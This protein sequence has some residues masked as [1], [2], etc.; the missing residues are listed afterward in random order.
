VTRAARQL[1]SAGWRVRALTRRPDSPA[2]QALAAA[3]GE[4]VDGDMDFPK[5]L[6]AA[7]EGVYGVFSVQQGVLGSPS[8][9][10]DSEV[11]QGRNVADA[12]VVARAAHLVYTSVS[13]RRYPFGIAAFEG[14]RLVEEYIERIGIPA[15]ILRPASFME[16]YV[17][18]AFGIQEGALATGLAPDVPEQ[19]IA[20]DD[21]GQFVAFSFAYPRR[22]V[23]AR[24]AIAG[25]ELTPRQTARALSQAAGRDIPYQQIPVEAIRQRNAH[26]A[27]AVDFLHQNGGYGVDIAAARARHPG[28]MT[29]QEWLSRDGRASLNALF[30]AAGV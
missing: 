25:D 28:L 20:L 11:R 22:Y 16:N 30:A 2:A 1:L 13:T 10:L 7:A 26:F 15:T 3:G 18:P 17:N 24:V 9:S 29:F 8:A 5:S 6:K 21:I 23:E 14:K 27:D 19:M 12:A 4:V